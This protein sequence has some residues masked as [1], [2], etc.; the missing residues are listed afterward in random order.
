MNMEGLV[1]IIAIV[2]FVGTVAGA[3]TRPQPQGH[4]GVQARAG[5]L[6]S[7]AGSFA[8]GGVAGELR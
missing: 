6:R 2:L 5:V 4:N 8:T 7:H 3:L 1:P